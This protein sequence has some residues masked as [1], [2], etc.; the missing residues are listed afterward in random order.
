SGAP[1]HR[2]L[3][4]AI[5]VR[6]EGEAYAPSARFA[7]HGKGSIRRFF[8]HFEERAGRTA[9]RALAL[10]PIAHGLDRYA[11]TRGKGSLREPGASPHV[12]GIARLLG[13][14]RI[15]RGRGNGTRI[16]G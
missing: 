15:V 10:L 14:R 3:P 16:A 12:T 8:E 2:R 1:Q 6:C 7:E 11:D 4:A 9:R 13:A 5:P